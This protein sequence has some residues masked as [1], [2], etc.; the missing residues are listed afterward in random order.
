MSISRHAFHDHGAFPPRPWRVRKTHPNDKYGA[1]V[2]D[3]EGTSIVGYVRSDVARA[4]VLA[5]N[6][7]DWES[8]VLR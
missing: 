1:I 7:H 2:V 6:T 5:V 8:G 3:A 4:I